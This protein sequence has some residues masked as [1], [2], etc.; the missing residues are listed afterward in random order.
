MNKRFVSAVIAAVVIVGIALWLT[1]ERPK[2]DSGPANF[3]AAEHETELENGL[4]TVGQQT[5]VVE[6]AATAEQQA[7]GLSGRTS[8]SEASG[9]L[10]PFSPPQIVSFWMKDMKFPIDIVWI[11]NGKVVG[12]VERVP[13]PLPTLAAQDLPTY[14]PSQPVD[15]VLELSAGQSQFFKVGDEVTIG[16]LE[17]T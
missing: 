1:A 17:S 5:Y 7:Q 3:E 11:A 2:N 10:F 14:E 15:Y 8:M 6:I 4:V 9:M 12:V 16:S 13:M